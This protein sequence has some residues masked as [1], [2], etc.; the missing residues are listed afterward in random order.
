MPMSITDVTSREMGAASA[1]AFALLAQYGQLATSNPIADAA[2]AP[3]NA[4]ADVMPHGRPESASVAKL[5]NASAIAPATSGHGPCNHGDACGGCV[6]AAT[7]RPCRRFS[8]TTVIAA[9]PANAAQLSASAGPA[10]SDLT[11]EMGC[12]D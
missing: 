1:A 2:F 11:S 8:I 10:P 4:N 5:S 6:C 12:S 7:S 3:H 9:I